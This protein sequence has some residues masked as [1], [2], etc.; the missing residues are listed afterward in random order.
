MVSL[1]VHLLFLWLSV[2]GLVL[3]AERS[4]ARERFKVVIAPLICKR[5]CLKGQ[6]RDTCEQG[7]NTTLIGENGH[8]GD[9]LTGPG[10]RVV[11]CPLT[12]MNGGQCSS[13]SHC[14]CPP[15]FSGRFCQY[16]RQ[17]HG[18]GGA[19][20]EQAASKHPVYTL[21]LLPDPQSPGDPPAAGRPLV[22]TH[23][24][25]TVPLGP[26]AG[27]SQ[28]SSEVQVQHPVVNVRVHHSP[29]T[30]VQI[31]RID[32]A[33]GGQGKNPQPSN[34]PLPRGQPRLS[35]QTQK[36]RGRCFQETVPKQACSSNPLP[37][38][39][40]Q[41]D[42]CGS[43]GNSWGQ[44]KCHKCPKLQYTGVQKTGPIL[45]E[46]G[47]NCPQ[48]YKRL[49]ATHCQDINECRMQGV[50]QD[51]ECLNTQGSFRCACKP[52]FVLERTRCV[53]AEQLEEKGPCYRTVQSDQCDHPLSGHLN[54]QLCC[55]SV[56][57]AWGKD[58]ERCPK[59]GTDAFKEICPAGKGFSYY[60]SHDLSVQIYPDGSAHIYHKSKTLGSVDQ[61]IVI[62]PPH[63][64]EDLSEE[65]EVM[66][67]AQFTSVTTI[68]S[69]YPE[70]VARPTSP[71]VLKVP[72]EQHTKSAVEIAPTQITEVDACKL[73]RN[74]CGHGECING[75]AGFF[76][77]CNT[78]YRPHAISKYCV[79][80][81]EC[82]LEPCG[83]G[84]GLCMNTGGSYTC[85][86]NSGFRLQIHQGK[87]TCV[88]INECAKPKIC[89]DG[90]RCVNQPG[91]YKCDCYPGY[92]SKSPRHPICEDI[93]E[94]LDPNM[95]PN[96]RCENRP[97]SHDCIP[98]PPGHRGQ[99]QVCYDIDE[100]QG[101]GVC[102]NGRCE[103]L[104]GSYRCVCDEGF[105]S[106]SNSKACRDINECED[107]RLCANG[108]CV[109]TEGSFQCQCYP[110]FQL[111]QEGSHC[112]DTDE[113]AVPSNCIGGHCI[114][115]MGSYSCKCQKGF[116][117]LNGRRCQ[118][119]D[120]CAQDHSLCQP[121]GACVNVDGNYLCV[122]N[123]GYLNSED[124]H[125][126]E[127]IEVDSDDKKECYLN[128]DD[129]VFC[130]SVLATNITKQECC[131]SSIG[132]GWGDHCEIY[133]CP[134]HNSAEFY[135][136]CPAGKGFYHAESL[137]EYGM[138]VHIDIDEC[139]LFG[140]EICKEGRCVNTQPDYEC[141]CQQGFYYDGNLLECI[142]VD[143]CHD[144]SN[145][146]NGRCVNTRGSFYCSC[147][148]PWTADTSN[149]KCIPPATVDVDECQDPANCKNG[150]CVNTPGSY[151]C[152]CPLPWA[153]AADRNT[154]TPPEEQ[155]DVDECQDPSYC[156]KG[157]CVNTLGSFHCICELPLTFSAALKQCVFDDRTAA[158]K[159]VCFQYVGLDH[160]CSAPHNGPPVTYSDCCCH[161]GRGWGPE[162]RTCPPRHSD[163]FSRLCAMDTDSYGERESFSLAD[164]NNEGDSSEEDSDE[165][166]CP[167]GRCVRTYLGTAC[168]CNTGFRLHHSRT[169]CVDID[170]CAELNKRGS[171][172]KNSHCINT[173][174]S[175][176]CFCKPGFIPARR[177]NIC[178]RSRAQ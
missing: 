74:I 79:D 161:I 82:E 176:K 8:S 88:D 34:K 13:R 7:N 86:C 69:R 173:S 99:A 153:L 16:S 46:F 174:G 120:E 105:T 159:D 80:M 27:A 4:A 92:K 59:D 76:C 140:N 157:L 35:P 116:Q 146:Q 93:D 23:S 164:Y 109:N 177:P 60:S 1:I 138:P 126:C 5:T 172:C 155:G 150:R 166:A 31:Y 147:T 142:D 21:H 96:E 84:R 45:G 29:E 108:R 72:P 38:L 20:G 77:H 57:A 145:C 175:Y 50:C 117:L 103:N 49:N 62:P 131:C 70:V 37:G 104:Q 102:P 135:S 136:L 113:C 12:C 22:Q 95:C 125:S 114:N 3:A 39:T 48:G 28:H 141:Y 133:P 17:P 44:N 134:V 110:G 10:F 89:G 83:S 61:E 15:E 19:K 30:S 51:G 101:R 151:Y 33:E 36:P 169:R 178:V 162:C 90:G 14:L 56:G 106:K 115:K 143:E 139:A 18:G 100:C 107:D 132:S 64:V 53:G 32:E 54:K 67:L 160:M 40:N 158:H 66:T 73:N 94:C 154:C 122:C 127:E 165:C 65:R 124:K 78:G 129:T 121:N 97:G 112:E 75:Q 168:E 26:G 24:S 130:D 58:C 6:C 144:E 156:K 123:E 68:G 119:I 152:I 128:L 41:E 52:G 163:I 111:T 42:C 63:D 2:Q 85:R 98:C 9:T 118:D 91:F 170:E 81:N 149:K 11:V 137:L 47:P 43:V 25:F 148:P 171:L 71:A 55:C 167:N 87:R